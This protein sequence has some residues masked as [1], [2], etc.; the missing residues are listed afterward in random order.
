MAM[1]VILTVGALGVAWVALA[2]KRADMPG[3]ANP[4]HQPVVG[5]PVATEASVNQAETSASA[6]MMGS[7]GIAGTD[8]DPIMISQP[9]AEPVGMVLTAPGTQPSVGGADPSCLSSQPMVTEAKPSTEQR[10]AV[11]LASPVSVMYGPKSGRITRAQKSLAFSEVG[12]LTGM[13]W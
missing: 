2:K 7:T 12:T 6:F 1:P 3:S 13:V 4:D 10:T 8:G 9:S 5:D 11:Q